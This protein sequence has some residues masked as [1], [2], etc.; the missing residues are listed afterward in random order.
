MKSFK[1]GN[2]DHQNWGVK[3]AI[4]ISQGKDPYDV[5]TQEWPQADYDEFVKCF[6]LNTIEDVDEWLDENKR[7]FQIECLRLSKN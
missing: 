2:T 1:H 5:I 6:K 7:Y 4:L 3:I